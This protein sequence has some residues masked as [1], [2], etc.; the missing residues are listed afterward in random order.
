MPRPDK[1]NDL[2]SITFRW[3]IKTTSTCK[4]SGGMLGC[5]SFLTADDFEGSVVVRATEDISAIR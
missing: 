2:N 5:V 3:S 1:K 4:A